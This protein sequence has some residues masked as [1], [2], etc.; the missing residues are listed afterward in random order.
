MGLKNVP[1]YRVLECF[2]VPPVALQL[3]VKK[4]SM[5]CKT[6]PHLRVKKKQYAKQLSG[7][8]RVKK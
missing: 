1:I 3:P 5:L 2:S 7:H 4:D 6:I 8:L